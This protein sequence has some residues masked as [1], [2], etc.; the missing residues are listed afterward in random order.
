MKKLF[1][2]AFVLLLTNNLYADDKDLAFPPTSWL[3]QGSTDSISIQNGSNVPIL[4]VINV[5]GSE[6]STPGVNLKNCGTITHINA[7][8]SAVC[9]STDASNPV[10]MTSDTGSKTASGTYQIKQ[11]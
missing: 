7:G 11:Q 3:S 10:T 8:S 9:A 1:A 5:A 6:D 2:L 4:I